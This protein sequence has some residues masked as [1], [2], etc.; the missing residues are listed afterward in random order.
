MRTWVALF[1]AAGARAAQ[2]PSS[3]PADA[4]PQTSSATIAVGEIDEVV[5]PC[6][7]TTGYK[8]ELVYV[9]RE[10][11]APA[12]PILFHEARA[13]PG[14]VGVGGTCNLAL[15]GV[16]AGKTKAVLVYRRAWE[17]DK[18]PVKRFEA[19]VTVVPRS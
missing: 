7:P 3:A 5:L 14:T 19:A 12:G 9:D 18:P 8:W 1:L 16:K 4:A 10:I 17:K 6:N 11:A 2:L 13:K 15:R